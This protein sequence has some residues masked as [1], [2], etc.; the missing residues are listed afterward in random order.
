V[1]ELAAARKQLAELGAEARAAEEGVQRLEEAAAGLREG[2]T[3]KGVDIQRRA[4]APLPPPRACMRCSHAG[5]GIRACDCSC[6]G[7]HALLD[8]SACL[9]ALFFKHDD[10]SMWL[11]QGL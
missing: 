5:W 10:N 8:S 7:A 4:R 1:R 2:L 9:R 11:L 3:L 6:S